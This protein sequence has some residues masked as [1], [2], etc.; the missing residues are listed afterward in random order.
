MHAITARYHSTK[1]R[2]NR[3]WGKRP[4]SRMERVMKRHP[5][6]LEVRLRMQ[7]AILGWSES[8]Y[9]PSCLKCDR[10]ISRYA[11][12]ELFVALFLVSSALLVFCFF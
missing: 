2:G 9:F 5:W 4:P 1:L 3:N 7:D 8:R 6:R 10:D 11:G 12:V